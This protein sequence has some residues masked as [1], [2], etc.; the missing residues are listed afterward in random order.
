MAQCEAR[1]VREAEDRVVCIE[2]FTL[3]G[4]HRM[5]RIEWERS[6][7]VCF[8]SARKVEQTVQDSGV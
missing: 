4:S 6:K 3:N 7:V 2:W 5:A 1:K 8:E